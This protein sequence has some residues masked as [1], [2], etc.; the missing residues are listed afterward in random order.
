MDTDT[1]KNIARVLDLISHAFLYPEMDIVATSQ[2]LNRVAA[3]MGLELSEVSP[4]HLEELKARYTALF[5]NAPGGVAAPPYASVYYGGAGILNQLGADVAR[6]YYAEAGVEPVR[7][8]APDHVAASIAFCSHLI[9]E[10]RLDLLHHYLHHFLLKW[11]PQ[12]SQRLLSADSGGFYGS[13]AGMAQE[14]IQGLGEA[15]GGLGP[16]EETV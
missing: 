4:D 16:R 14:I 6:R 5:I 1:L 8:D 3:D 12:F 13:L 7:G 11:F 9:Q 2:V 15:L 10:G